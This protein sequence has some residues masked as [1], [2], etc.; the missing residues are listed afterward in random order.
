MFVLLLLLLY[1]FPDGGGGGTRVSEFFNKNPNI[2]FF[3]LM[4]ET[5]ISDFFLQRKK[6]K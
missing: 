4:G 6:N 5:R 1:F 3:V 2:K